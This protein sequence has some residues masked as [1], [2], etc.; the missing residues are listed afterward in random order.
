MRMNRR[1]M[2]MISAA[3]CLTGSGAAAR[4]NRFSFRALGA[5]A[6]ITLPGSRAQAEAAM[7]ACQ[8]EVE[9]IESLFSLWRPDSTLSRLNLEGYVSV[10]DPLFAELFRHARTVS[11]LS[12][13]GFDVTVQPLWM[14]QREAGDIS[15]ARRLVDWRSVKIGNGGVGFER[16]GMAATLNGIA[17]GYAADRVIGVLTRAGYRDALANLGEFRAVGSRPDGAPWRIG[18]SDPTTGEIAATHA[19][20]RGAIATSEPNGTLVR[21]AAH[22]FDPL[23]RAGPRWTSVTVLASTGWRADAVST[24]V[25]AAPMDQADDLL[26]RCGAD[27]ATLISLNGDLHRWSRA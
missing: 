3:A 24:A 19:L 16:N 15:A 7:A 14:A 9:R 23:L 1:R 20:K 12:E 27:A 8:S 5:R 11:A 6:Q 26:A 22:I 10:S 18:V 2:M 13:G 17:Q 25:A 4:T 21:G